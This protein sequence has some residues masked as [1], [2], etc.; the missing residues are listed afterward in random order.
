LNKRILRLAIPNIISNL[1]VPLLSSVDTA[2]V[3]RLDHVY[4]L[5]AIAVGGMIFNI[6]YWGF[7]F[8]RMGTTGLTAQAYGSGNRNEEASVLGRAM[9]V[10]LTASFIIIV[11]RKPVIDLCFL[12]IDSSRDVEEFTRVYFSYRI[13]AA[14]AT[15]SLYAIQGW[16]LGM[17]NAKY[18]MILTIFVNIVNIGATL[19]FVYGFGMTVDGVALGTVCAQ[20]SG[21]AAGF[22]L[23]Y[24]KY[25]YVA[26]SFSLAAI[27]E[28]AELRRFFLV[29]RDIFIRTLCLIFAFSF[30]TAKSAEAGDEIL[31][32]NTILLQLWHILA[33]GVDG[34][35]FAAE[36][37]VGRYTGSG[38]KHNLRL[39][40]RYNLYWG[41]GL[42][43]AVSVVYLLFPEHILYVYT[44]KQ[45][46][47]AL[48]MVYF[49]WTA[50]APLINSF[51]FIWDGVYIGATATRPMRNSM[52]AASFLIFLPVYYL[53]VPYLGNHSLWLAMTSFMVARGAALMWYSKSY[54]Y[55]VPGGSDGVRP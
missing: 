7:G 52:I 12:I 5:G 2:I 6:I 23:F 27:R 13:W 46:I 48:A 50:M 32:I 29:N 30:F 4:Y 43:V 10:A 25:R 22:I 9:L 35:A 51:C 44:D 18:P 37:L 20:Y 31:A 1:S 54:I 38:D 42:G 47:I 40:I 15:L 8:L 14:P 49:I 3:G 17:Q 16:F 45:E 26:L 33:Y 36:S 34:F 24:R 11:F 39:A 55:R 21:V 19:F 53:S 28:V 41:L